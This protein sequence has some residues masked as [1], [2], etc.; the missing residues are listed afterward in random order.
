MRILQVGC[1]VGNTAFPLL[2]LNRQSR[3]YACDFAPSAVEMVKANPQ[4]SSQRMHAFVADIT[5]DDLSAEVPVSSVDMCTMV[6]VLSAITPAKMPA[7]RAVIN[8]SMYLPPQSAFFICSS[9][10]HQC[11][12]LPAHQSLQS[13]TT[14]QH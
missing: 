10:A 4:Y 7:V 3:V 13:E 1:G 12:H 6:F 5:C 14:L 11:A 2:E 8:L 9:N